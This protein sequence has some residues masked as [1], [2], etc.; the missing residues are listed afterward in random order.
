[1]DCWQCLP[2]D[3]LSLPQSN[4]LKEASRELGRRNAKGAKLVQGISTDFYSTVS[5]DYMFPA[6][7]TWGSFT[8]L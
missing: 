4:K 6:V 1:M 7:V 8:R 5:G 2:S 3:G